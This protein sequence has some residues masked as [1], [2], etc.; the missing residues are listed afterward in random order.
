[1]TLWMVRAGK[2]GERE[3]FALDNGVAV[4]GW[5][6]LPDM[7]DIKERG[8]LA[9]LLQTTYPDEKEKTL[10]NWESQLWPFIRIMK[11]GDLVALPSKLRSVIALGHVSGDYKYQPENPPDAQHT[12]PVQWQTELPR[13]EFGQDL[14]Y[15]FGAFM[16]VCRI[17]R[18]DAEARVKNL[19]AGGK[20]V[21]PTPAGGELAE[22][23]T[24]IDLEQY[25]RDQISKHIN[26]YFKG[27]NL[28]RLVAALLQAQGYQVRISPEGP[29]GGVD[30]I[31]GRGALGFEAP[32]L[33]VQVKSSD[34]PVDV[35][36]VRELQGV[37]SAF[38]TEQ[39]LFVSWGGYR[40]GVEKE[41]ARQFFKVRLWDAD[42]LVQNLQRY[43]EQLPETIQAELPLKRI[44]MLVPADME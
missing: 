39:G 41:A 21:Q 7:S 29:D 1:M 31:G 2:N 16:T 43:Y 32:R 4:I 11:P 6:E 34:S 40:K 14:L 12:R 33:I 36:V 17:K 44:W 22:D 5:N 13:T 15:S 8:E 19:M 37:M 10:K 28:A 25:A 27:H 26:Q 9:A 38:D 23:E 20:D 30:I 24:G 18:N 3:D 35:S 42:D